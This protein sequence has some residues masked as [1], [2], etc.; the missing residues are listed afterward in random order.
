MLGLSALPDFGWGEGQDEMMGGAYSDVIDR[1]ATLESGGGKLRSNPM[2]SARGLLHF[3]PSTWAG[4]LRNYPDLGFAPADIDDDAKQRRAAE[5]LMEREIVPSLRRTLGR[6]PT[7]AEIYTAWGLGAPDA[8]KLFQADP[9]APAASLFRPKVASSNPSIFYR[10]P[11]GTI[12]RTAAEVAAEYARRFNGAKPTKE[13]PPMQPEYDVDQ[14]IANMNDMAQRVGQMRP[15]LSALGQQQQP[16]GLSALSPYL[17]LARQLSPSRESNWGDALINAGAAMMQSTRP[18]F[19]G[20]LG[21]GLQAGNNT[22]SQGREQMRGDGLKQFS[23]AMDLA[24]FDQKD[25]GEYAMSDGVLYNKRTG[26]TQNVGGDKPMS[27]AGKLQADLRAGRITPEQYEAAMQKM[28]GEGE[29][30]VMRAMREA[31]IDPASPDGQKLIKDYAARVGGGA[32]VN[33]DNKAETAF[34]TEVAKAD[35]KTWTEIQS[36]AAEAPR[37]NARLDRLNQLLDGVQTGKY[38]GSLMELQKGLRTVL[39][40]NAP[41]I[42]GKAADVAQAEAAN[43][44]SNEIAL[45]LRNPAGGAGMPGAMSDADRQFLQSMVPGLETTAEGRKLMIE[46]AKKLNNRNIE[47]ARLAQEY[48]ARNGGKFDG[49]SVFLADWAEK[50]PLFAGVEPPTAPAP[51][52]KPAPATS[53]LPPSDAEVRKTQPAPAGGGLPGP[54]RFDLGGPKAAPLPAPEAIQSMDRGAIEALFPRVSEMTN[55]QLMALH[56]RRRQL[57]GIG[58]AP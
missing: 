49:W 44:L 56:A 31:G 11:E 46:T 40:D 50:N 34:N 20:G 57:L 39:G 5:V 35:A 55:D 21:A 48:R 10:D 1:F 17:Q 13:A 6:E 52:A 42:F 41:T 53:A 23:L 38:S 45:A 36:G 33:I 9:N 14:G 4:V 16:Q 25:G 37:G 28:R 8:G 3:L 58:G 30:P 7:G 54:K 32:T 22:L 29:S 12:P 27:D 2:S 18:D 15:G 43:A 51:G 26:A 24:K 19:L 47:I